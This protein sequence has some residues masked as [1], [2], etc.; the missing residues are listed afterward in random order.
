MS[1]SLEIKHLSTDFCKFLTPILANVSI[2]QLLKTL[3]N[4]RCFWCFQRY[5]MRPLSRNGSICAKSRKKLKAINYFRKKASMQMFDR[6]LNTPL[7]KCFTFN[8][9]LSLWMSLSFRNQSI[10]FLCKSMD[11]FLYDRDLRHEKV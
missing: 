5:K 1:T 4:Q 3:E 9:T 6:V 10:D 11:W 2:L 7:P 8:T